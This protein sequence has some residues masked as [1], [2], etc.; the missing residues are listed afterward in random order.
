MG[1]T[2]ISRNRLLESCVLRELRL[3]GHRTIGSKFGGKGTPER[4][5]GV[6]TLSSCFSVDLAICQ[7]PPY[8]SF[9]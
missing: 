3:L 5:P 6:C 1:A 8:S 4:V 7:S 2:T 9:H